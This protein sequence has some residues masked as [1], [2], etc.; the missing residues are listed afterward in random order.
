MTERMNDA[1]KHC[2]SHIVDTMGVGNF[3]SLT[4]EE[5]FHTYTEQMVNDLADCG[6][7]ATADEVRTYIGEQYKALKDKA[8]TATKIATSKRV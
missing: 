6:V 3:T 1:Y 8:D 2:F 5:I 7:T 4:L